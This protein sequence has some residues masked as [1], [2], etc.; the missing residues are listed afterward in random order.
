ML[1][2]FL[3]LVLGL[4]VRFLLFLLLLHPVVGTRALGCRRSERRWWTKGKERKPSVSGFGG[5]GW[6]SYEP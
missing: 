1:L 5:A 6:F 2:G 4:P 3:G